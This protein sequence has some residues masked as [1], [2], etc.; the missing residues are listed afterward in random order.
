MAEN[1]SS[2]RVPRFYYDPEHD[3]NDGKEWSE[4][5]IFDLKNGLERGMPIELVAGFLCRSGSVGDV[6]AKA[7]EL[8]L[9]FQQ[10]GTEAPKL[11]RGS[12]TLPKPSARARKETRPG[13]KF[14]KGR[15]VP[16]KVGPSEPNK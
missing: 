2:V 13:Q 5:D 9:K 11:Y 16:R 6:M 1:S 14:W 10:K 8:S 4:I 15:W 12:T 3:V 7:T